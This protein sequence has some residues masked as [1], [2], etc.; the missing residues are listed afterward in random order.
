MHKLVLWGVACLSIGAAAAMAELPV[1]LDEFAAVNDLV[2][3]AQDRIQELTGDLIKTEESYKE[4]GDKIR[5]AASM[6]AVVSQAIAEHPSASEL[7][8]V[9]PNLRDAAIVISRSKSFA[10]AAKGVDQLQAA[11]KGEAKGAAI[12]FNW[13]KLT[14]MH[15]SMEEMN[16]RATQMR[17]LLRRPK[18]PAADSRN[19]LAIATLALATHADTHEV[20]NSGDLPKW[21]A[22][23]KE[24]ADQMASAAKAVQAK[25]KEA[26]SKHFAAGME[27]CNRCHEVFKDQ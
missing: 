18:D 6:L 5:Q 4:H 14:R 12:E 1:K 19:C 7:K 24:L 10:D 15:P 8:E 25:D 26:A 11:A 20:K 22:F 16:A 27:T 23:S 3:E 21:H 13:A 9:A 2:A 17:R